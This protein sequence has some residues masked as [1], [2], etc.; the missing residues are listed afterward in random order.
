MMIEAPLG[1]VVT[2][3]PDIRLGGRPYDIQIIGP[4]AFG[5][6]HGTLIVIGPADD[7]RGVRSRNVSRWYNCDIRMIAPP[8]PTE[9]EKT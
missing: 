7:I 2:V 1:V 9:P 6:D 3:N 8:A 4:C 5:W